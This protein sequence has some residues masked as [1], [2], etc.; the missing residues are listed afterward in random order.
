L[1]SKKEFVVN[2]ERGKKPKRIDIRRYIS[3]IAEGDKKLL[4]KVNV[5]DGSTVRISEILET[6]SLEKFSLHV[7]RLKMYLKE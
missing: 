6:L 4:I 5:E 3:S 7:H 2:R 1:L